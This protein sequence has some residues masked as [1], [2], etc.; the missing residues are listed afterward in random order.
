L[1][2]WE[3]LK[4]LPSNPRKI[5]EFVV[6]YVKYDYNF[7]VYGVLWYLPTPAEVLNKRI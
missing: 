6:R 4:N 3:Q 2:K 5:E 1:E 7:N